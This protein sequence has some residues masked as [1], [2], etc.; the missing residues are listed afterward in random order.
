MNAIDARIDA[1]CDV[2]SERLRKYRYIENWLKSRLTSNRRF[3]QF[4]DEYLDKARRKL[5][6]DPDVGAQSDVLAELDVAYAL[7]RFEVVAR[8]NW[9]PHELSTTRGPDFGIELTSGYE[10]A[11]EVKRIRQTHLESQLYEAL[12]KFTQAARSVESRLGISLN[13]IGSEDHRNTAARLKEK[14]NLLRDWIRQQIHTLCSTDPLREPMRMDVPGFEGQ[15]E[16]EFLSL[17]SEKPESKTAVF[18]GFTAVP[19]KGNEWL[20]VGDAIGEKLGQ[21]A[22]SMANALILCNDSESLDYEDCEKGCRELVRAIHAEEHSIQSKLSQWGLGTFN[23]AREKYQDLS[24]VVFRGQGR[25]LK[26]HGIGG[27]D[28]PFV[29]FVRVFPDARFPIDMQLSD[30][31]RMME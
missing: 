18:G 21:F 19:Y 13:Y 26:T 20:K 8:V 9:E 7:L 29:N 16:V 11:A 28:P 27:L 23:E 14:E 15:L 25:P 17:Q 3:A 31:L 4:L 2:A 6:D 1:L 30:L 5:K 22:G 24:A 12:F 10:F